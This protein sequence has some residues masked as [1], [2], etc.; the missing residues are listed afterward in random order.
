MKIRGFAALV[1]FCA[2]VWAAALLVPTARAADVTLDIPVFAGGYGTAFY[3]ETARQFEALRPGVRVN[4]YGD[5]RIADQVR[6]R[7]MDGHLP[8]A[9]LTS[10]LPWPVLIAAGK[11]LDLTR[12]LAGQ[13]WEDD[14]R[15]DTTFLPGAL[16]SW[17]VGDRVYG[18]PFAHA[19]WTLFYDKALFR[20][21][22]WEVP[23][24]WD[25]FFA[26]GAKIRAAGL[27]PLSLPGQSW[28]YAD[29][30]RRAA[31]H[32][33]LGDA[34]WRALDDPASAGARLDPRFVR[35]AALL[36]RVTREETAPG[37][38]GES[39]T[40][41]EQAFLAGRAAMTVSGSW[42][43][44]E[45]R[46]KIPAGFELGAMNF[47]V[48]PDGAADPTTIQ[49][50]SDSFFVF[51]TGDA[52]R[53]R[54]TVDFLRY[55]TSRARAEAFVRSA[56]APVAIRGV[57]AAAFSPLMQDTAA[58]IAQ[59]RA[60]FNMPQ[61]M[62]QPPALRQAL[63][64]ASQQLTTGR[65]TPDEFAAR[66]EQ[67]AATDRA[68]ATDPDRVE[69]RH[70]VAAGLLLMAILGVA[71]WLGWG[72]WRER[73]GRARRPR[74]AGKET[75]H[76]EGSPYP[77]S[78]PGATGGG[79]VPDFGAG[80]P[81]PSPKAMAGRRPALPTEEDS[82]HLGRLR[83]RFALGFVGPALVL[84]GALV[85][86]PGLA[87]LAW[88]FTRWDGISAR[89]W[90]GWFNF[91]WLLLESDT[92]WSALGNN[93]FLM[94]V[95]A[96][97]VVPTALLLAAFIHRGGRG[98]KVFQMVLLFPNLLGG[99][100]AA[101]LWL[102]AYNPDSGLVNAALVKFGGLLAAA[103]APAGWVAWFRAFHGYP[104]LAQEHL[105]PALIPIYLWMACGFNL[106]LYLAAMQG[107][108]AELYEAAELEGASPAWQFFT[109]TL[110]LIREVLVVS[111]VFLV[112]GGLNAFEL[113]W[114]LTNQAPASGTHTL[115]T[116]MVST[117]FQD[118][119]IGRATAVAVVMFVLVLAGS[120]AVMRALRRETVER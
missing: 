55:L 58:L 88:A 103:H 65:I 99:V 73:E 106:V 11:V 14:A 56:D 120:A 98:A 23:H 18:L 104:W 28:L 119:Q 115:G 33:L 110:P 54:L 78:S 38:E 70:G 63:I 19:C 41:A 84:Y 81:R 8:D 12:A 44:N 66:L 114:L 46:G 10:E 111:A 97:V 62:L 6:V 9:T 39:H 7:V 64:D 53:E 4:L 108:P 116:L 3:V 102:N 105:Y 101:L 100:A 112:I 61:T 43:V 40:G 37:W 29:A 79:R 49:T 75:A 67:A 80:G 95:P 93:L 20:A 113:V 77:K 22:G 83:G 94:V 5:P 45:M 74:R 107:I 36:Q 13:N 91:K 47:P 90:A 35:A 32:N 71:G 16:D 50:G 2:V 21:H 86:L 96:L 1:P 69:V 34:A 109:I 30:F 48:F 27:T 118:F 24:T 26:L 92:F 87:A 51:A 15:W 85:L 31:S 60:A 52:V 25:E 59:A 117:M 89:S 76:P 57:P 82:A 17:R 42:F 68:R 72:W